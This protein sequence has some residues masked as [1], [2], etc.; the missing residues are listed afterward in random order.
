MIDYKRRM[1]GK[2]VH[3]LVAK[4]KKKLSLLAIFF[5]PLTEKDDIKRGK[6][7]N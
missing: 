3:L 6:C 1:K 4:E 5:L 7:K 2:Y